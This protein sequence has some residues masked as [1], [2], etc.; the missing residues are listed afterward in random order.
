MKIKEIMY[1]SHS[2]LKPHEKTFYMLNQERYELNMCDKCGMIDSTYELLWD[3]DY[4]LEG[5]T[6][7][8]KFCFE[9]L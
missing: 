9:N 1:R 2:D 3:S 5:D 4:D 8:C 6:C 7:L